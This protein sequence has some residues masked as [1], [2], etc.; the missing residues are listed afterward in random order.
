[1][2]MDT[3][4][5]DSNSPPG[6]RSRGKHSPYVVCE[7]KSHIVAFR[8]ERESG[9]SQQISMMESE[10]FD[11]TDEHSNTE[12]HLAVQQVVATGAVSSFET[13]A[14]LFVE[15][16]G[17]INARNT[18]GDTVLHML[19]RSATDMRCIDAVIGL[20]AH[21]EERNRNA[22]TALHLACAFGCE[23]NVLSLLLRGANPNAKDMEHL[24]PLHMST[25]REVTRLLLQ[26]GADPNTFDTSGASPLLRAFTE[27]DPTTDLLVWHGA[28]T[29]QLRALQDI[30]HDPAF[31]E[32]DH[33]AQVHDAMHRGETP[34]PRSG[35]IDA[36]S[37]HSL[38]ATVSME[39]ADADAQAWHVLRS[40]S[41]RGGWIAFVRRV[42][43]GPCAQLTLSN[44]RASFVYV[45]SDGS[46]QRFGRP[47]GGGARTVRISTDSM[48]A[49]DP[50]RF[51]RDAVAVDRFVEKGE[52]IDAS[53]DWD[54]CIDTA[55][56][57]VSFHTVGGEVAFKAIATEQGFVQVCNSLCVA[58]GGTLAIGYCAATRTLRCAR[59]E[60]LGDGADVV[61]DVF[62]DMDTASDCTIYGD[63]RWCRARRSIPWQHG[64]VRS[65]LLP[66]Y[67]LCPYASVI[68]S[69]A[70]DVARRL[71]GGGDDDGDGWWYEGDRDPVLHI[72][73][74]AAVDVHC[75]VLMV[76]DGDHALLDNKM[77]TV[78]N[79]THPGVVDRVPIEWEAHY[80]HAL[81]LTMRE[82][83]VGD[84]LR[85]ELRRTDP[86]ERVTVL[87]LQ[88][89]VHVSSNRTVECADVDGVS[90]VHCSGSYASTAFWPN[91]AAAPDR[92]TALRSARQAA[93]AWIRKEFDVGAPVLF[94][95]GWRN[96][97]RRARGC[98]ATARRA[99]SDGNV[100]AFITCFN[101]CI[102]TETP[103][104][105]V[106]NDADVLE[107]AVLASR[108]LVEAVDCVLTAH[109]PSVAEHLLENLASISEE[110]SVC[111]HEQAYLRALVLCDRGLVA[112]APLSRL[113][114]LASQVDG[115]GAM[116][117]K[118]EMDLHSA[119]TNLHVQRHVET[120]ERALTSGDDADLDLP[121]C[122]V[123][124]PAAADMAKTRWTDA[125]IERCTAERVRA[126][127]RLLEDKLSAALAQPAK[128]ARAPPLDTERVGALSAALEAV[129]AAVHSH[130]VHASSPRTTQFSD[131]A[132]FDEWC[133]RTVE[134]RVQTCLA[135]HPHCSA[136]DVELSLARN[137]WN[138]DAPCL[139]NTSSAPGGG[140]LACGDARIALALSC[141]HALCVDCALCWLA[142]PSC[143]DALGCCVPAC[144]GQ[145]WIRDVLALPGV[146]PHVPRRY[147][148][149]VAPR[150]VACRSCAAVIL[151]SD[152][153][154]RGHV[155]CDACGALC[156]TEC[157]DPAPHPG[158]PCRLL[159]RWRSRGH[160]VLAAGE[161]DASYD[162]ILH[163]TKPC[164]NCGVPT[165][166]SAGCQHMTCRSAGGRVGC[167]HQW[168][169]Q[170]LGPFHTSY[171]CTFVPSED[172]VPFNGSHIA[173][174]LA[175]AAEWS[176]VQRHLHALPAS[177]VSLRRSLALLADS[178]AARWSAHVLAFMTHGALPADLVA[179][180][181]RLE[182]QTLADTHAA[183]LHAA[184]R[185]LVSTGER[186]AQHASRA[187][188]PRA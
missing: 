63:I 161:Q 14:R 164:P 102:E 154:A 134:R 113:A 54:L 123:L 81:V 83:V 99:L 110:L 117:A 6:V 104:G 7:R 86:R 108:A 126:V 94:H 46:Q 153:D 75:V 106:M 142:S 19:C 9:T 50:G 115:F 157:A 97:A 70:S 146:P 177:H 170:C 188:T 166:R 124:Q 105:G 67:E 66:L 137:G 23:R 155:R 78:Q 91:D 165:E 13:A 39:L 69:G 25:T 160:P 2:N 107:C 65:S 109:D 159:Q 90:I 8:R 73:F 34:M 169:W 174:A 96:V 38:D 141:G 82:R 148:R 143:G 95:G 76:S 17:D 21:I 40:S 71:D 180:V 116:F 121:G 103:Y 1:M 15:K 43:A 133:V 32:L 140:C 31:A 56:C 135:L 28:S 59:G 41:A 125:L 162:K 45:H 167:G 22:R 30:D 184:L 18:E 145:A 55:G 80:E 128:R 52:R 182:R 79:V 136:R 62:I 16:G 175:L 53:E 5:P 89:F 74:D 37:V 119:L 179:H 147:Y 3:V 87:A 187:S 181:K 171:G 20:G 100:A 163:C 129:C 48:V 64:V 185:Q 144:A 152:R 150:T 156:C 26:H 172:V 149:T 127:R 112:P 139:S 11:A 27:G 186:S 118:L 101:D 57:K 33:I 130:T 58:S 98:M 68:S 93:S 49:C 24:T 42:A 132:A 12:L 4:P 61:A 44:V 10:S 178:K 85:L 36:V 92:P 120:V 131:E 151:L 60:A 158:L 168:C 84:A 183:D 176:A 138:A 51:E 29:V 173:S 47:G 72:A 111:V 77:Y 114:R 35:G 88:V 122:F